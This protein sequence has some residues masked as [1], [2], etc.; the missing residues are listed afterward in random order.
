MEAADEIECGHGGSQ[1]GWRSF[2]PLA[3]HSSN[4]KVAG[5]GAPIVLRP[6]RC[7]SKLIRLDD[8]LKRAAEMYPLKLTQQ[9]RD[10]LIHCTRIKNKIK[11]RLKEVGEGTQVV[12]ITKKELD[13]LD[14]EIPSAAVYAPGPHKKRLMAVM[15]KIA[16]L[17]ASDRP[18]SLCCAG[19]V[20]AAKVN[21]VRNNPWCDPRWTPDFIIF[22]GVRDTVG[23]LLI[24]LILCGI[25][26]VAGSPWARRRWEVWLAICLLVVATYHAFGT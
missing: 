5:F 20:L 15:R 9:Q 2:L 24:P 19:A 18:I 11:E 10:S 3:H 21:I 25:V 4:A 17:I 14:G 13:H 12:T 1:L 6:F 16:D 8:E 7:G 26:G 22:W 23:N